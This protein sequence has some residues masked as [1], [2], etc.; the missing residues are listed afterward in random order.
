MIVLYTSMYIHPIS[1]HT[2]F[3]PIIYMPIPIVC[4]GRMKLA[5]LS[6]SHNN[7]VYIPDEL[8]TNK[9]LKIL[10]LNNNYIKYLPEKF[11]NLRNL[12]ELALD[13]NRLAKLPTSFY[14]LTK[15]EVLRVDPNPDMTDPTPEVRMQGA[16]AVVANSLKSFQEMQ[17]YIY[18]TT[19][20][21]LYLR[22]SR[23]TILE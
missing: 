12:R 20:R 22:P 15:L 1:V 11:G 18:T 14:K 6:A 2:N 21:I 16:Q 5:T 7:I 4:L 10:R 3:I 19:R 17:V 8:C 9:T 13:H 23:Y